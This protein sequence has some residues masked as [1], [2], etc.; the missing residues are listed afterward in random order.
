MRLFKLLTEIHSY[1]RFSDF[2]SDFAISETDLIITIR[3]L[4]E[5]LLEAEK[6]PATFLFVGDYTL[7]EPSDTAIDAMLS[8]LGDRRYERVI[9]IGGG[10][11]ID[12]AKIFALQDVRKSADAFEQRIPIVKDKELIILPATCGTGSEVTNISIALLEERG[13]KMGLAHDAIAADKAVLIQDTLRGLPFKP[14]ACSAIDALVHAMESYL[15]PKANPY[16]EL[17]AKE[18]MRLILRV[19]CAIN[20]N[21][22]EARMD[23]LNDILMAS[24]MA[25][26]SFGNAGCG[27]VHA[28]SYPLGGVYH[29]PHGESNYQFL[30]EV[31]RTYE[32]KEPNGK[33]RQL[34]AYLASLLNT[35]EDKAYDALA[36]VLDQLIKRNPLHEYGMKEEEI[37]SFADSVIANQQRLLANNYVALSRDEIR[38]IYQSLY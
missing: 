21:G 38:D 28:M 37:E 30:I 27:A 7:G 1:E 35:E 2:L 25:G 19:F 10:S 29:V 12:I 20:K 5:P 26:I 32:R 33:I 36:E 13:V 9:A 24:N 3:E 34:N 31:F 16:T 14:Y 11:V 22:K 17:F 6:L 18:A 8:D 15:S 23:Y 4:Y